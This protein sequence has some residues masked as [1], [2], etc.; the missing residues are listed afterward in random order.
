MLYRLRQLHNQ[1]SIF[2]I[3]SLPRPL[4][5]RVKNISKFPVIALPPSHTLY[6]TRR[7][8]RKQT[9]TMIRASKSARFIEFF[10][11]DPGLRLRVSF[12]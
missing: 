2:T 1:Y 11:D 10:L 4:P 8:E 12:I 9:A 6:W 7:G 5:A 3:Q